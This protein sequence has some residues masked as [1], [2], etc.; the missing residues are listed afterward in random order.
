PSVR[1][2][3]N[4]SYINLESV[5]TISIKK[6]DLKS[7][8]FGQWGHGNFPLESRLY[9]AGANPEELLENRFTR[10]AG[11]VPSE[12]ASYTGSINHFQYGGGLNLR[13][14]AGYIAPEVIKLD[15]GNDTL[16][17][18]FAGKAGASWSGEL[19]FDKLINIPA[20]GITKNFHLDTYLFSDL[21]FIAFDVNNKLKA[22]S[23]R[24]DAGIG[25]ALTF[26]FSPYDINPITLRFDVPLFL[27]RPPFDQE[28]F[29]FRYVVG[30]KR[31]F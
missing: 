14:Y 2:D 7:R 16:L 20:K 21:G 31:S 28:Y 9:L 1:S 4:Y 6:L 13:G 12:W 3:Y 23:F 29:D 5:N 25:T 26:K 22:G 10:A 17:F 19:D 8:V 30:I 24:M 18:A 11:F 15:N 27:N